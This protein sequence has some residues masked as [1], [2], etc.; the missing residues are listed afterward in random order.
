MPVP[1]Q[2]CCAA[3]TRWSGSF[4]RL[5]G[6]QLDEASIA[7]NW[8]MIDPAPTVEEYRK[9]SML[10][11][12]AL[13]HAIEG[14]PQDRI[15]FHLCWGSWHGP[16]VTDIAMGDIVDVMLAIHARPTRSKPGTCATNTNGAYGGTATC[17]TA[18]S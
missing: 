5:G 7:E 18:K 6:L 11:V 8:D 2:L 10:R 13:N 14:L 4:D 17:R 3:S 15:R 1:I 9:F 16:H 12:D